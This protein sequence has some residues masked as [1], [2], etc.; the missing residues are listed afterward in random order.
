MINKLRKDTLINLAITII[1]ILLFILVM[2]VVQDNKECVN[3]PFVYG[4]NKIYKTDNVN[5]VCQCS[6]LDHPTYASFY[7]TKE[8]ISINSYL[9]EP[10]SVGTP[11]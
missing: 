8:N 1:L 9:N 11:V 3:N 7:F 6:F 2:L 5:V 10:S 4:A